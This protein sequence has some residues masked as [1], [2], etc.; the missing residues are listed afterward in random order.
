MYEFILSELDRKET[1]Y[2][3]EVERERRMKEGIVNPETSDIHY[4]IQ[5]LLKCSSISVVFTGAYM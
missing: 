3:E 1:F 2:L 5:V 4:A